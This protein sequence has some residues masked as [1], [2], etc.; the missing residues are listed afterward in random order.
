MIDHFEIKVVK[1]AECLKFYATVLEPLGIELKWFDENAAGFGAL[2]DQMRVLFLIEKSKSAAAVHLAFKAADET[3][4]K[5]FHQAGI[6]NDYRCNGRPGF[7]DHY[8]SG[9]YAAFLLDPDQN[10][11]EAVFRAPYS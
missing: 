5:R 4:V 1:F 9:Y 6:S 10:N 3:A 7:R 8:S 11:I 2:D